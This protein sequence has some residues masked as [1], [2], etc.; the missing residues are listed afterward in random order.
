MERNMTKN[1]GV[2]I[3]Y[4]RVSTAGQKL[5]IQLSKLK[6]FGCQDEDIYTDKLSG[7]DSKRPKLK[8]CLNFA[9]KND[10]LVVTKLDRLARSTL[11]LHQIIE[12]L[13]KKNVSN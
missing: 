13:N 7:T 4:A 12:K 8:D 1:K 5:D 6:E 11:H 2:L 3:G 10:M 9:R